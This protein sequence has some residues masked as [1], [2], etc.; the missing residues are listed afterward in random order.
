METKVTFICYI[1]PKSCRKSRRNVYNPLVIL[2]TRYRLWSHLKVVSV[3]PEYV[4]T[5]LYV[6]NLYHIFRSFLLRFKDGKAHYT[7]YLY[8]LQVKSE[9]NIEPQY[10][11]KMEI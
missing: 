3:S 5:D 10:V 11:L 6:L 9:H 8:I 2:V 4:Q 1:T 7:L